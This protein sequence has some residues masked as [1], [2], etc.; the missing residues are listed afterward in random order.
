[1]VNSL[2]LNSAVL[3]SS[4]KFSSATFNPPGK[5]SKAEISSNGIFAVK[6]ITQS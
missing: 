4:G 1:M 3:T 5:A 6:V 2:T